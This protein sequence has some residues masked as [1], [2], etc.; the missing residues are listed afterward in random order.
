VRRLSLALQSSETNYALLERGES[1]KAPTG[2]ENNGLTDLF[3]ILGHDAF[4]KWFSV[5]IVNLFSFGFLVLLIYVGFC[6]AYTCGAGMAV[7]YYLFGM[8][9][10][11]AL[12]LI[13]CTFLSAARQ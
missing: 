4:L 1:P 2:A 6:L 5:F 12:V 3:N 13:R 11:E 8:L 10:L 7:C 9:A